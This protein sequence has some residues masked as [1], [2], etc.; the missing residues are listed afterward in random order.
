MNISMQSIPDPHPVETGWVDEALAG[1]YANGEPLGAL[2]GSPVDGG[3]GVLLAGWPDGGPGRYRLLEARSGPGTGPARYL[4]VVAFDGP[5]SAEWAAAEEFASTHRLGPA[6]EAVAGL[7]RVLRARAADNAT[8]VVILAESAE[9]IDAQVDAVLAT[10]V[11]PGEDPALLTGPDRV[12]RYRL[13]HADLPVDVEG[14]V[15]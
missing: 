4:Q 2:V 13:V 11:L 15:R 14:S 8:L 10:T 3:D 12:A 1:A 7:V 9:A 6:T 5:R